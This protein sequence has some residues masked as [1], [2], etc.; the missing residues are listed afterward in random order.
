MSDAETGAEHV[1]S[2]ATINVDLLC[3]RCGHNLRGLPT[4][5]N[6][7]ACGTPAT[8]PDPLHTADPAWLW[9]ICR[10]QGFLVN[11]CLAYALLLLVMIA[12]MGLGFFALAGA[13]VPSWLLSLAVYGLV[14][15][16]LLAACV[17]ALVGVH[18]L[19]APEPGR[20]ISERPLS[21][22]R[23]TRVG[24]AATLA[25]QVVLFALFVAGSWVAAV[26]GWV[27]QAT[28][29]LSLVALS[30]YLAALLSRV[31]NVKLAADI[32]RIA[33]W[34]VVCVVLVAAP[35]LAGGFAPQARMKVV[36]IILLY[37][38]LAG[39]LG[40]VFLGYRLVGLMFACRAALQS[41]LHPPRST[42]PPATHGLTSNTPRSHRLG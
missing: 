2:A 24:V 18:R 14:P 28:V 30:Q 3:T 16:A 9:G 12:V 17:C 15:G 5:G 42:N 1:T 35:A 39:V 22:R 38:A 20:C 27:H 29:V 32:K 40:I 8:P 6:C 36:H 13:A 7:P 33:R 34:F 19:T 26:V 37:V 11:A 31:P 23:V 25:L 10:G 4:D 41:C 21:L